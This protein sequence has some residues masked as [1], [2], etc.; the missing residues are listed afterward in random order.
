LQKAN[1][2]EEIANSLYTSPDHTP[3]DVPIF[4]KNY[5]WNPENFGYKAGATPENTMVF[6]ACKAIINR[7]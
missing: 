2:K 1:S 7:K 5:V 4:V 3:A 6:E